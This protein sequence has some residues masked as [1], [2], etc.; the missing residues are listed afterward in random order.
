MKEFGITSL[1]YSANIN[2]NYNLRNLDL[3]GNVID[4]IFDNIK[5]VDKDLT[6][7]SKIQIHAS[8][9][10]IIKNN[11]HTKPFKLRDYE[12]GKNRIIE[13]FEHVLQSDEK[14]TG[15]NTRIDR[16]REIK[17]RAL[18]KRPISPFVMCF[19]FK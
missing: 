19:F 17:L 5:E 18:K 16:L 12:H 14:F 4:D 2:N 1:A 13:Y 15:I 10:E 6:E 7:N 3:L 8:G 11:M 9:D